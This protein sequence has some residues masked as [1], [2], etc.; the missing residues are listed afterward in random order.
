MF[1]QSGGHFFLSYT[2]ILQSRGG[3][4]LGFLGPYGI[5][6]GVAILVGVVC[7][8]ALIIDERRRKGLKYKRPIPPNEG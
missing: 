8:L 2:H 7:L 5:I 6:L 4:M 1:G 3:G